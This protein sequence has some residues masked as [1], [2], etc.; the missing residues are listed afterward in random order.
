MRTHHVQLDKD[1]QL[2]LDA[3]LEHQRL[4]LEIEQ[5]RR[6]R[7][8]REKSGE[9]KFD[10]RRAISS[11][12]TGQLAGVDHEFLQ[13]CASFAGIANFDAQRVFIPW[14]LLDP[15]YEHRDLT[16][17]N[18]T[19]AGYLVGASVGAAYDVL[20]RLGSRTARAGMTILD[21][22]QDDNVTIPRVTTAPSAYALP[23]EG[24]AITET[25]PVLGQVALTPKHLACTSDVSRQFV[26]QTSSDAFVKMI[27]GSKIAEFMDYQVLQGTGASGELLGLF[28]TT[29]LQTQSGT[30]LGQSG[31]T[32][33]K[34]L[35]A[36]A[37][38]DDE[39]IAFMS[40]PAVRQVLEIRE[41]VAGNA[42]FV[43]QEGQV[44]D[45]RAYASNECPSA[46]MVC[47][48]WSQVVL[49]KYGPP[50][51]I[52]EINPYEPTKFKQGIIEMRM[53]ISVDAGVIRPAA[54][55]K[56]TSIT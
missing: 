9:T 34:K 23:T 49:C 21:V 52:L 39:D 32:T 10:L 25:T 4:R 12:S 20:R 17:A 41:K 2:L 31:V 15:S 28:N 19:A 40:T 6:A 37:G 36:E 38:A 5:E 22:G 30:T 33:M 18:A 7:R 27:M 48:P 47:G 44:A 26:R 16:A 53:I 13:Q 45:S 1:L 29:G 56:S 3:Q 42:G 54:F 50:G 55:V 8:F 35:S 46:S 14:K 11:M 24:T 43:W 51:F